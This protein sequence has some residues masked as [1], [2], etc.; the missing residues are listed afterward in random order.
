MMRR[1]ARYWVLLPGHPEGQARPGNSLHP[2]YYGLR[3]E[4]LIKLR[5][6]DFGRERRD[7][8]HLPVQG[9]GGK[10]RNLPAHPHPHSLRLVAKYLVTSRH[11]LEGYDP[12]FGSIRPPKPGAAATSALEHHTD[13]VKVQL[14]A[15][16]KSKRCSAGWDP[17]YLLKVLDIAPCVRLVV[18]SNSSIANCPATTFHD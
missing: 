8:L 5:V 16:I 17:A 7:V 11:G 3:R 6:L 2:V 4:D 15:R 9:K 13:I 14:K 18:A 10:L 12:L 1:R